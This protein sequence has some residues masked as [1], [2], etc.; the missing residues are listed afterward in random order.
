MKITSQSLSF[1]FLKRVMQI[2]AVLIMLF[3]SHLS[4][5]FL[6]APLSP[7]YLNSCGATGGLQCPDDVTIANAP[8]QSNGTHSAL[9]SVFVGYVYKTSVSSTIP[10]YLVACL[11][12]TG[13]IGGIKISNAPPSSVGAHSP[14]ASVFLGYVY[15]SNTVGTVP[16]YLSAC[17]PVAAAACPGSVTISSVPQQPHNMP[18]P[19]LIGYVYSA[20]P[21]SI[22][23]TVYPKYFIGS[24]IYVPPGQGPSSITY[25]AGIMTGTTV[26]TTQSWT[27][28]SSVGGGVG[29]SGI[30][31][32]INFSNEFGGSTK[33]TTDVQITKNQNITYTGPA[34]NSINHD[35][36]Q[37]VIFLGVQVH[38]S[39]DYLGNVTWTPDFSQMINH[40]FAETGYPITV[41]CLRPGGTIPS[42]QCTA[43]FSFLG[44][45]GIT[46]SDYST[47]VGADPFSNP[48][49]SQIPDKKRYVL[50]DAVNFIPNPTTST[51]TYS[52]SNNTSLTNET[53]T[54]YTSTV[55]STVGASYDGI[56]LNSTNSFKWTYSSTLT[57]KTGSTG[58]STFTLTLPSY[59]YS[60]PS[61]L[62][63]Y[64]DTIFK[65]FMFSFN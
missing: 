53:T 29:Y 41:G 60:G 4:Y 37:V 52:E 45:V 13:C 21:V 10:I 5:A 49:I 33:S 51:V 42:N 27:S 30:S 8:T 3:S 57:D 26:S 14:P 39:V 46:S 2:G 59:P 19:I 23:Y 1:A 34:S 56:S 32:S 15:Q 6:P 11:S 63:I 35:Y 55:S 58:S 64:E 61:T 17:Q 54:S 18:P 36:D 43:L 47:I 24:V 20:I 40:G 25:G 22:T 48:N 62:F 65:T 12:G 31:G 50:I 9:P 44:S 16:I 28:S 38:V 7:I